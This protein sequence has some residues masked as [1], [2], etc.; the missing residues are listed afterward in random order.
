MRKQTFLS[1]ALTLVVL[2]SAFGAG[3]AALAGP[4][5]IMP[6]SELR[7]GMKG[8]GL[9]A[10]KG[11]E[12]HRFPIEV[13][14]VVEGWWPKSEMII[15]S[16][17]GP[18]IDEAGTIAGMSGSPIYVEDRLIGALAYGWSYTKIPLA[19]VTPAEQ[20]LTVQK[21]DEEEKSSEDTE[22]RA[23]AARTM[24]KR[25][26]ELA[27]RLIESRKAGQP[28]SPRQFSAACLRATLPPCLSGRE[29]QARQVQWTGRE[30]RAV[31]LEPLPIPLSFAGAGAGA[32]ELL[33]VMEGGGLMP[34]QAPA[35]AP[36][37]EDQGPVE[38]KPGIPVGAVFVT[39][40]MELAATGTL[41]WVDGDRIAAFG[42]SMFGAGDLR[43][44]LALGKALV[45]VP[46]LSRSFRITSTGKI[47]GSITQDREA[48]IVG[49]LG[50]EAPMFPFSVR[51]G[52]AT[53]RQYH[54]KVAGYWQM[55]PM[56]T[57]IV[58]QYSSQR[59]EGE[60]PNTL[61]AK[62]RIWLK[63]RPEPIELS[64]VFTSES[65]A[66]P[67]FELL[68]MPLS[69]LMTN[70]FE[71]VHVKSVDYE[72]N[73]K[74]GFHAAYIRSVRLGRLRARPGSKVKLYVRL[75]K[76]QGDEVIRTLEV[77]VPETARPG[78]KAQVLVCDAMLNNMVAARLDPGLF[79]PTSLDQLIETLQSTKSN[80]ELIVRASFTTQGVR[81]GGQPLPSLPPSA[82]HVLRSGGSGLLEPI[83]TD[84]VQSVETPWVLTGSQTVTIEII[85]PE[86][87]EP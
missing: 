66:A 10:L 34:V 58:A 9:T 8:Y 11:S 23:R 62:A 29:R 33:A 86:P 25:V 61:E 69:A 78:S 72:L 48:A 84:K 87:H 81:Y 75:Q 73:V 24:R 3:A 45:V 28:L 6:A 70:P 40:D 71:K 43:A 35:G 20:M 53:D 4:P 64:N 36:Q 1:R 85:P 56:F 27:D 57:T 12:P 63:E 19:G 22:K 82:L 16:L 68:G 80:R 26:A 31:T 49:R 77:Q 59:W 47:I 44:P 83:I 32:A 79:S 18:I 41:T 7:S 46:S 13:L 60:R 67:V 52:G 21:I 50:E 5:P 51:I 39:G 14:A 74:K 37:D 2:W 54:Y 30:G 76:W 38:I 42:H 55:L 15:I 65:P 17:S